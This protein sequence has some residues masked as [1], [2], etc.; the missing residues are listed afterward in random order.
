MQAND[1]AKALAFVQNKAASWGG[2][3]NR[4]VLMGHSAGAHLVSLL[5]SDHKLVQ[6]NGVQP[7]LGT[8]SLDSAALNV[9]QIM[10]MPHL[11]LYDKAFGTDPAFWQKVSP[12]TQ[13]KQAPKLMLLVC[14]SR[15]AFTCLQSKQFA[16]KANDIGGRATVLPIDLSHREINQNLGLSG[17]YTDAVNSFLH[18]LGLP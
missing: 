15:R 4:I 16:A 13:L 14:S 9:E 11:E 3:P 5:A 10:T 6:N 12:A 18:T 7:W 8:I 17:P 2:D 1:V